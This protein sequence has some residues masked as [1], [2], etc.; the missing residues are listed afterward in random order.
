M[1]EF[2]DQLI[3][4]TRFPRQGIP[5]RP[6]EVAEAEWDFTELAQGLDAL[7]H[8]LETASLG[9]QVYFDIA[10]PVVSPK[11]RV[12]DI[13]IDTRK[14]DIY[15][16]EAQG[17]AL[18]WNWCLNIWAERF[19]IGDFDPDITTRD[20]NGNILE[21]YTFFNTSTKV[22]WRASNSVYKNDVDPQNP[23]ISV[24]NFGLL[25]DMTDKAGCA[26]FTDGSNAEWR[27]IRNSDIQPDFA[28]TSLVCN[29]PMQE[30]GQTLTN[31]TFTVAYNDKITL[32]RVKD[33][34]NSTWVNLTL[35]ATSFTKTG[36]YKNNSSSSVT[37]TVEATGT[38]LA[39]RSTSVSW[40]PR[41]FW[42]SGVLGNAEGSVFIQGLSS[43]LG[44]SSSKTV[45]YFGGLVEHLYY[46]VPTTFS[47]PVFS[48]GG[49]VGGFHLVGTYPITNQFGITLTYQLWESDK[50]NL[51]STTVV[52]S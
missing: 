4:P 31:P 35:P 25:P 18:G 43:D 33:S 29:A 49:F 2:D 36:T 50:T 27:K 28:I 51:G 12:G 8:S 22:I 1:T 26:L 3:L 21:G 24:F 14:G 19:L 41:R 39:S 9:S 16:L 44:A 48:V 34:L 5:Q 32:A 11:S 20:I 45:V 23:W 17:S 6:L 40:N 7:K 37:F 15:R 42:G 30:L 52:I 38:S 13:W 46:A 10:F 47:T